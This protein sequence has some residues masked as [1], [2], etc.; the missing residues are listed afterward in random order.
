[1]AFKLI[2]R[3]IVQ[4]V[5]FRPF[6]YRLAKSL[7]LKGYVKNTGDGTVEVV[8]DKKLEEF[9]ERL[10]KE[11]PPISHVES[12][13][14]EKYSGRIPDTFV[15]EKSGGKGKEISLPPPDV[16]VC[17]L[18]LKELFEPNNRRYMYPFISCTDCG[19]RFAIAVALPYDREN[20]TLVEFPLCDEC[21]KEYWNIDDRR[22][23]AQSIACP[24]CGP[25]YELIFNGKTI[26]GLDGIKKAAQL[27][28]EGKI[29]AIKG[30]GGYHIASITEDEV[31]WKLR[32]ILRRPQQPFA[33]MARNLDVIKK[34]AFVN[35]LEE[36]ELTSYIRPITILRKRN[37]KSFFAVAP[38]LDTIGV[39][40]PYAPIHYILFN[41]LKADFLVMTSAN[42]PGEPMYIDDG[43]F[44][45]PLDGFLRHNMK[46]HNRVDDS[47]I[48]I[49]D[50]TRL[51]IRRSRGFVPKTFR[52]DSDLIALAVGAE[53]YNSISIL[54]DKLA[55]M[56]QYIGN[57]SNFK[58]YNEFFKKAIS[59]FMKFL[60]LRKFDV[61]FCD[62]H[63]L[64]NTT[65]FAE[66]FARELDSKLV[67]VQH[68]F[69]HAMSV[70]AEKNLDKA[71]AITVDGVGYGFDGTIWGGEVLLIDFEKRKFRRIG[72]LERIKLIGGDLAT[73]RPLRILFSIIYDLK[74]DISILEKYKK[75]L[76]ENES[77]DTFIKV[78]ESGVNIPKASSAGRF[79]DAI[80]AALEVCFKRTY[81]G[82]PAMKVEA[83]T[84]ESEPYWNKVKIKTEIEKTKYTFPAVY[85]DIDFRA[86][87]REIKVL[88]IKN[89]IYDILERYLNGEDRGKLAFQAIDYL[90]KGLAEI[91][92]SKAKNIVV[93]S[94]GVTLNRYFTSLVR[95]YLNDKG[96]TLYLNE[97]VAAGD[98]GISFGQL[99]L[100]KFL[101]G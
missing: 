50:N 20:T 3:G 18:C 51:I 43:V 71:V 16:A 39:M 23:Y 92:A 41:H 96:L 6:I 25:N 2:I 90:A 13:K 94:G 28:D 58:T 32:R 48:K 4:G 22:Y 59:F 27:L 63:P 75:Y 76:M 62:L 56:S 74:K 97:N 44:K 36:K 42:Y 86:F 101:E 34:V 84:R 31:V 35:E 87:N 69:A 45:L 95:K 7:G 70:M 5:G 52:L 93:M 54:K 30:I 15:I 98:N 38:G 78:L 68:H 83:I 53:L 19:P 24:I 17:N 26:K 67:R 55:I 100:S 29:I 11:K 57:T 61:I 49:V 40:L 33:V 1:M 14:V 66:K 12:V 91:A 77:F 21:N 82:E 85:E 88:E 80:A 37:P 46:I 64:Y 9:I 47:V 8:I 60:S 79:F 73:E 81:E 65:L 99:Y 72:R 10:K 89:I